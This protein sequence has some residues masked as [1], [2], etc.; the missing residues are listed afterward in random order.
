[1]KLDTNRIALRMGHDQHPLEIA[2]NLVK[3]ASHLETWLLKVAY[4]L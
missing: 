2:T 3:I 4:N 1:M